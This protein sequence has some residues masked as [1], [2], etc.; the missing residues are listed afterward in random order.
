MDDVSLPATSVVARARGLSDYSY[1]VRLTVPDLPRSRIILDQ[2]PCAQHR[3]LSSASRCRF[4]PYE[5]TKCKTQE[6]DQEKWCRR[7]FLQELFDDN[8]AIL[9]GTLQTRKSQAVRNVRKRMEYLMKDVTQPSL[10]TLG[11]RKLRKSSRVS[12]KETT[13]ST[14][15]VTIVECDQ[16]ARIASL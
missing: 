13:R 9:P 10:I 4:R 3:T 8:R 2:A 5:T 7:Q 11:R 12:T 14:A 15:V 1:F 6:R 16:R